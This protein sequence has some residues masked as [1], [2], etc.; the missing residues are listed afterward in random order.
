MQQFLG[1]SLFVARARVGRGKCDCKDNEILLKKIGS[2]QQKN[3]YK[4]T[5][6]K[7]EWYL[8]SVVISGRNY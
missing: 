1:S 5:P 6:L 3:V 4:K 2:L 7:S 8:V